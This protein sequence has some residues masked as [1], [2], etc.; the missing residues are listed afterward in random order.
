VI[1]QREECGAEYDPDRTHPGATQQ[2]YCSKVCRYL[3]RTARVSARFGPCRACGSTDGVH[4]NLTLILCRRCA[5]VAYTG[6]RRKVQYPTPE[7]AEVCIGG[8]QLL[9]YWCELCR[10]FHGTNNTG[11]PDGWAERVALIA[12]YIRS[13]GFDANTA[14]GWSNTGRAAGEPEVDGPEELNGSEHRDGV[15]L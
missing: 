4:S 3:A 1:C 15:E 10:H 6:C 9:S 8:K 2:R 7:E 14:R 5:A 11:V 13:V 12:A